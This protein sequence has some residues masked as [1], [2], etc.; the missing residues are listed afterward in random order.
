METLL[1]VSNG[2]ILG[3]FILHRGMRRVI[4]LRLHPKSSGPTKS[5]MTVIKLKKVLVHSELLIICPPS[6][7]GQRRWNEPKL[8]PKGFKLDEQKYSEGQRMPCHPGIFFLMPLWD[9]QQCP[10][11]LRLYGER[12][13]GEGVR[14]L[15]LSRS[16]FWLYDFISSILAG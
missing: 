1:K 10:P 11:C 9:Q 4:K 6:P 14:N 13:L 3:I 12:V 16:A 8:L 5:S 2:V 15:L 7:L